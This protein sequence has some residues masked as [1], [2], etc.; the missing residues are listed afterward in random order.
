[1]SELDYGIDV[2]NWN[3]VTDWDA[4]AGNNISFCSIKLTE[5]EGWSDPDA[6][7]HAAGATGAGIAAGGYHFARPGSAEGQADDF[8]DQLLR[9]DLTGKGSMWPMLD[10]EDHDIDNINEWIP[11]FRARLRHRTGVDGMLVYGNRWSW[12]H[13]LNPGGWLDE[14]TLLWVAV[15]NGDPGHP[16]WSHPALVLHQHSQAGV[17]PGIPGAVDRDATIPGRHLAEFTIGHAPSP[18]PHPNPPAPGRR[19][20]VRPGDT[21]S[22]LAARFD[23]TVAALAAANHIPNP[24]L[25]RVG[26]VLTVPGTADRTYYV[27]PGDT[28]SE[29]AVS[30]GVTVNDLVE[31]NSIANP[32]LIYPGQAIHY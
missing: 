1:M 10:Y 21:L 8:A 29:I 31:R 20:T 4:V 15:Y 30:L 13:V 32:N 6:D 27:K 11:R 16:G 22:E 26:Q 3:T 25:I 28:L 18:S 14:A 17:V 9:L 23:T 12:T 5:G 19:Y 24:D 2:S 7:S